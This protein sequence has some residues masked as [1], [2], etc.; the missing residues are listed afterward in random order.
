[1][2]C[3]KCKSYMKWYIEYSFGQVHTGYKCMCCGY[4]TNKQKIVYNTRTELIT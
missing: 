2:I 4:D 1:M 3:E